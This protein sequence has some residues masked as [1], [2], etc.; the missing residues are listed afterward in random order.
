M[1]PSHNLDQYWWLFGIAW[2]ILIVSL[3]K[4]LETYFSKILFELFFKENA[5]ENVVY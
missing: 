4:S 1:A 2:M 3:V 5:V